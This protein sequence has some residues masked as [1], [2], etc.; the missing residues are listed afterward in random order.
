[1]RITAAVLLSLAILIPSTT[2]AETFIIQADNVTGLNRSAG[3]PVFLF[4]LPNGTLVAPG[5]D[6]LGVHD[7]GAIKY[8]FLIDLAEAKR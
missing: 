6:S 1:M 3:V 5:F 8:A 2:L 4:P 7:P